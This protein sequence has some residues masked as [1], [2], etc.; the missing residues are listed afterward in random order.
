MPGFAG[1]T[2]IVSKG[3]DVVALMLDNPSQGSGVEAGT[4]LLSS[5]LMTK[6]R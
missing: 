4:A 6:S 2:N 1:I 5:P 3:E